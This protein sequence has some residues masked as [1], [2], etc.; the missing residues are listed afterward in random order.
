[1]MKPTISKYFKNEKLMMVPKKQ[2]PKLEVLSFFAGL[3]DEGKTYRENEVNEII[4]Q[5]YDDYAL[6]R[7][8]LIDYQLLE[9]DDF[10]KTY[11][12]KVHPIQD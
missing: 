11:H 8:N 10:G 7:R 3:F 5:Y 4:Q 12:K 6:I 2:H 9:R 1:M